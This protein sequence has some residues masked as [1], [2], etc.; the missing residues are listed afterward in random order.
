MLWR[1]SHKNQ[2]QKKESLKKDH[3]WKL[4]DINRKR[5]NRCQKKKR[6]IK[7][8]SECHAAYQSKRFL[9]WSTECCV[10]DPVLWYIYE[11]CIYYIYMSHATYEWVMSH[12]NESCHIW[13]SHGTYE[14]IMV[15]VN[16]SWHT[17]MS[18]GTYKWVMSHMN[19]LWHIWMRHGTYKWIV[20]RMDEACN[21]RISHGTY[22]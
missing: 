19:E 9:V 10:W 1:V 18:H 6:E 4:H 11:S 5:M 20:A 22:K 17:W 12:M 3:S 15:H 7:I 14:W 13:M 16:E 8:T 2:C 21:I